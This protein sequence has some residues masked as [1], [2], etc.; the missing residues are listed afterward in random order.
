M[1]VLKLKSQHSLSSPDE[2]TARIKKRIAEEVEKQAQYVTDLKETVVHPNQSEY[3]C[4]VYGFN[5]SG[6]FH[7]TEN[8]VA[9]EVNLP[10]AAIAVKGMIESQLQDALNQTLR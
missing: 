4:K 8:E 5:L 10:F 7:S 9:V 6:H 1:P 2:A 3:S